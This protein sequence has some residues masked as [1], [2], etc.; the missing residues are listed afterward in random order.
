MSSFPVSQSFLEY[1]W[2]ALKTGRA[3][4][5]EP[6]EQHLESI[7][8]STAMRSS[9]QLLGYCFLEKSLSLNEIIFW[10]FRAL[11]RLL[12]WRD[13]SRF[14]RTNKQHLFLIAKSDAEEPQSSGAMVALKLG[15][16]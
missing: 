10:M 15:R 8:Q 2:R 1:I 13:G 6:N 11:Y 9:V 3:A 14:A 4:G 12:G 16:Q 7:C 5:S